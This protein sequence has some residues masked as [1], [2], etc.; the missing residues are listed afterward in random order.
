MAEAPPPPPV[1]EDPDD[2][3]DLPALEKAT[4]FLFPDHVEGELC[5][6]CDPEKWE[7]NYLQEQQQHQQGCGC[8]D[9]NPRYW[10]GRRFQMDKHLCMVYDMEMIWSTLYDGTLLPFSV[11]YR[12]MREHS[13]LVMPAYRRQIADIR[14]C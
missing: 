1:W 9:C 3:T 10:E 11:F 8:G 4:R 7:A 14:V 12:L 13:Y 6:H 5:Y 2:F